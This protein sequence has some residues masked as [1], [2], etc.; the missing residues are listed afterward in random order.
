MAFMGGAGDASAL[1]DGTAP[2]LGF[3]TRISLQT[4]PTL[5]DAVYP[6]RIELPFKSGEEAS[7]EYAEEIE[8]EGGAGSAA[9]NPAADSYV[10]VAGD[11]AIAANTAANTPLSFAGGKWQVAQAG[12]IAE[13]AL[14]E[15]M[16]PV[17]ANNIRIR[18]RRL[19]GPI[20][21]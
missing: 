2:L 16:P 7:F 15:I 9:Q 4:G 6:N 8:A 18:A 13:F 19:P 11:P 12:Q 20:K 3:I 5:E 21:A 10:V 17:I 1:A 14:V